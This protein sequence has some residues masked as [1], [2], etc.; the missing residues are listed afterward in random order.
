MY[1]TDKHIFTSIKQ[2]ILIKFKFNLKKDNYFWELRHIPD[3]TSS[4]L[5]VA[6]CILH[7]PVQRMQVQH[8]N[9][10]FNSPSV[11]E[12]SEGSNMPR[13]PSPRN[14]CS[15]ASFPCGGRFSYQ[16]SYWPQYSFLHHNTALFYDTQSSECNSHFK[17]NCSEQSAVV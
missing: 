3:I 8:T 10:A 14:S 11:L 7:S 15:Q 2:N 12:P 1:Q 9:C 5:Q 4:H 16:F 13:L 17:E 6:W